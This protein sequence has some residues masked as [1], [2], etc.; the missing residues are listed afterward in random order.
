ML[1][2]IFFG[3][4]LIF[5]LLKAGPVWADN[6]KVG[7][8]ILETSDVDKASQLVNSR[9]GDWGY[10]TIV[11]RED[12]L[13]KEKWQK[14]FDDCRRLHLIPIVRLATHMENGR[15][16][17]AKPKLE[18]LE[19]W[20]EF[21][22]QLNW[23]IKQQIVTIFNEPNHS[24][25]WG[26]EINPQ[27]YA[28]VLEK[29]IDLLK[30]ENNNF[31]VLN[32]GLD[33]AA[34]GWNGTLDEVVFLQQMVQ[35]VPDIF[36]K[37]DAWASHSYP[38][39]GFVGLP[40]DKGRA[41]IKGYQWELQWLR[42]LGLNK[43]LAI[44]ITETGWPHQEGLATEPQFYQSEK[45]AQF[46]QKGF[47]YW[48][49]DSRVKAVTPFVLNYPDLPFD[50]FSWLKNDGRH[51]EQFNQVLGISKTKAVPE[52]AEDYEIM[53]IDLIDLLPT[54]YVYQG[55][56][57]IKN[58]GQWIMGER[59]DFYLKLKQL[60]PELEISEIKLGQGKLVFPG[61]EVTLDFSFKT[62]TQSAEHH[63]ILGDKDYPIYTF[64]PFDLKNKK[65]SLWRQIITKL[66][67][68]WL[69]FMEK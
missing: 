58:T 51:Y 37:L 8:H 19:K 18:D 20:P 42:N 41:T 23:P 59:K 4:F 55:K 39:Y 28:L 5:C 21:L 45:V 7:I 64:K 47:E 69:D 65:V 25:E 11:I 68:W 36:N 62:G 13:K 9:G 3:L 12:D 34:D 38:N 6:N 60:K 17:W 48:E 43:E 10:V 63:L 29:M 53:A 22:N 15:G 40:D 67:I 57:T 14:F 35:A 26:G 24:K 52:Q 44:Y 31:F 49:K 50:H 61:E 32:A 33:Q 54:N 2:K 30:K 1:K 46:F 27:E 16:F 56:I 66:K